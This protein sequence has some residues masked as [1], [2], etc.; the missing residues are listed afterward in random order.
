MDDSA[1]RRTQG[2]TPGDSLVVLAARKEL[3]A[4]QYMD[5]STVEWIA[6]HRDELPPSE[7]PSLRLPGV[8]ATVL[9]FAPLPESWHAEA[10][11]PM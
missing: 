11:I 10:T 7:R 8:A 2:V 3:P 4:H 1:Q 5:S 9:G 6:S